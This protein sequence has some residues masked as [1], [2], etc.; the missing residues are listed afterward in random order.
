VFLGA[1]T[2]KPGLPNSLGAI[3][4]VFFVAIAVSGLSI[5]GAAAWAPGVFN[6]GSLLVAVWMTATFARRRERP[7]R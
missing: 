3:V 6:G 2:I 4:G 7:T 1:T 5:A